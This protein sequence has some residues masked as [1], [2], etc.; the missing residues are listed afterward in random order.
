MS[1]RD[2]L[3]VGD[4]LPQDVIHVFAQEKH[5]KRGRKK[6]TRSLRRAFGWLKRKK[7]KSSGSNGQ[8]HG[9]GPAL[10]LAL[11]G[12]RAGN[13][14]GHKGG[15]KSGRQT[16]QHGNSH[17]VPKLDDDDKT[18][19]P[20]QFQENVFIESSRSKYVEDLH[21]EALEGLKMMQQEENSNGVEF[22]DNE[23]TVSTV[24]VQT[25]GESGGFMTDSTIADTSSVVS[26]QSS[27]SA[28]SSRSGLTR[29][30][31]TFRP[32]NSGKK[33]EKNKTRRRHRRTVPGIPR[34]VQK[35]LGL[36][37][38]GWTV[39]QLDE[40]QLYNGDVDNSPVTY[41]LE[42]G[43]K[44]PKKTGASPQAANIIH[45]LSREKVAQL[46]AA[47][48]AQ[49]D[50]LALLHRL[51]HH[52]A[53]EGRPRSLAVP[54]LTTT[55]SLQQKPPSLV[56]TMSPQATYMSKIIPN[57]VLP[58]SIDVVEISRGGSRSSVRM[59]SKSSLLLS[60]PAPSRASSRASSSRTTSSNITSASRYNGPTLSD[61]SYWST[62][63]SSE[64]LVSD[65]STISSSSTPRQ[66]NYHDVDNS[67]KY[68]KVNSNSNG[69]FNTKVL[70]KGEQKDGQFARSLS[71]MKPKKA[72]PPPSR[73]NSLH[74]NRKQR[75]GALAQV[76]VEPT[77][78]S[79]EKEN[80][81]P[82]SS[83]VPSMS[84]D[85]PGYHGDTSSL[86][87]STGSTLF[88]FNKSS[89]LA[90]KIEDS[91]KN[92]A[93]DCKEDSEKKQAQFQKNK[94]GGLLSP[95]SGYSS[96]EAT[97]PQQP[98]STSLNH[99]KGFLTKLQQLFAGSTA[100]SLA[101]SLPTQ[102]EVTE[103]TNST[104]E[105]KHDTL[106]VSPSVQT[107]RELF[108]IPPPPKVHAPPAP[109][110]EVWA[111][112]KRTFELLLG[113]PAPDNVYA[114]IK[115]NPKDRRQQRQSPSVS[116]EGS[117]KSFVVERK[118]K[119][120]AVTVNESLVAKK[121]Q[122][123]G[124][125]NAEIHKEKIERLSQNGDLKGNSKEEKVRVCDMLNG[126][127][128]KAVEQ[129]EERLGV[130]REEKDPK[131]SRQATEEKTNTGTLTTVPLV[132][133]SSSSSPPLVDGPLQPTVVQTTKTFPSVQV[134][135]PESSWPPPPSTMAD[136]NI[137]RTDGLDF[138]FPPPPFFVEGRLISAV[139]V[140]PNVPSSG[141]NL[142]SG[143]LFVRQKE[144]GEPLK[145][146]AG[147]ELQ[148]MVAPSPDIPPPP[149]Y[150]APSPPTTET[151]KG[152]FPPKKSVSTVKEV[153]HLLPATEVSTVPP[154]DCTALHTKETS[155]F[156]EKAAPLSIPPPPPLP[157][158]VQQ[159][160]D[161]A[162]KNVQP[163][164][165]TKDLPNSI[166]ILH[167]SIPSPP[168][169][170][171][172]LKPSTDYSGSDE[173][174]ILP[175]SEFRNAALL[176]ESEELTPTQPISV[177]LPPPLPTQVPASSNHKPGP[178]S[179][180]KQHQATACASDV[181]RKQSNAITPSLLKM[182]KLRSID[183]SL[184]P[185]EQASFKG[186]QE[187]PP[188]IVT[189]L[190]RQMD[191][192]CSVNNSP[193]PTEVATSVKEEAIPSFLQEVKLRSINNSPEPAE[194][195]KEANEESVTNDTQS[196]LQTVK[197]Q[198]NNSPEPSEVATGIKE[199]V[200]P[201]FTPK[202]KFQANSPKALEAQ[203]QPKPEATVNQQLPDKE[204]PISSSSSEAPQKPVRKSL[205]MTSSPAPTS[206]QPALP[207]SQSVVVPPTALPTVSPM[208]KP[209]PATTS[210]GSMNLQEV[211]RLRTATRSKQ[212]PASRLSPLAPLDYLK[213]PTSTASF[214]FS[215]SN[216][217]EVI[218]T[219]QKQEEMEN[220]Q[221][222]VDDFP[223]TKVASEG[224][225]KMGE[226]VPPPVAKKPKTRGKEAETSDAVEQTAGQEAQQDG[227][228]DATDEINGTAGTVQDRT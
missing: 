8:N 194:A 115:K 40:E 132:K 21:T 217:K 120:T 70:M 218:E 226:K 20:P 117:V 74:S 42:Q 36:D 172:T 44:S 224:E 223:L 106:I 119:N 179:I 52:S 160:M 219:T 31:S 77:V 94:H 175:P 188:A 46:N 15:Q 208:K 51:N 211:I 129:R 29:Q 156:T 202:V 83:P 89:S 66:K 222:N 91:I 221:K 53:D 26:R 153:P 59:V 71:V 97:S 212:G 34:H 182:V 193:E 118:Q 63:E 85:S 25:D 148:E 95:S 185:Q 173:A 2:S 121:V 180:E 225:S 190:L 87:D 81:K 122:E 124:N 80:K 76:A 139:Q 107:L 113:P 116:R 187:E 178:L 137:T 145:V 130:M 168:P 30:G 128:V 101:P 161:P 11:D 13:H 149:P 199:E 191:K 96:Q 105:S 164:P 22:Q 12:H 206:S 147:A 134:V 57:A 6:R 196:S 141:G 84:I 14:G 181:R 189:A 183:N 104:C 37:R 170:E 7:R 73:S 210:S 143:A 100:A 18:P 154:K 3:G 213:S 127:L 157:T 174:P 140:P 111:H 62:S 28:R 169:L 227:L 204:L 209:P 27:V 68:N 167:Q 78:L 201:S 136:V 24:T 55:S 98:P 19:A 165:V 92:A 133:I 99:K 23:S 61:A 48:A 1:N 82:G 58:P 110:P 33:S 69:P 138:P 49:R 159:E 17:A 207:Q 146:T 163:K 64:T 75:S 54:W 150:T 158:Q 41:G 65:S 176:N 102:P 32:L 152:S 135:S 47:H 162:K 60:S 197:L 131:T 109:P 166:L 16:H 35:E 56:M 195:T 50:D 198:A 10:D 38:V 186:V 144:K 123:S 90:P 126:L 205:I 228:K 108:N 45:P 142:S 155:Q 215:K 114:I 43:A 5:S 9:M 214:I 177:P 86:D 151:E 200:T 72:P 93:T 4:L 67:A 112:S 192:L 39:Q 220:V 184:E 79:K 203:E 125:L 88:T 103:K 216:K 171:S